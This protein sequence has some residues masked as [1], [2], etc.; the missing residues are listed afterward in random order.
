[1]GSK[2][3]PGMDGGARLTLTAP[4]AGRDKQERRPCVFCG[5]LVPLTR[6]HLW[7]KQLGEILPDIGP[8][9]HIFGL[10]GDPDAWFIQ[11]RP[12]F[13]RAVK[14]VCADCNNGWMSRL[15]KRARP[16][17]EPMIR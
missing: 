9:E 16:L 12:P 5:R 10:T 13:S 3:S 4:S 14:I 7:S 8:G 2:M 11:H 17:L 6:E 1:M 15:E